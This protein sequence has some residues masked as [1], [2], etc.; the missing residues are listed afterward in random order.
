MVQPAGE[1]DGR[2]RRRNRAGQPSGQGSA[3]YSQTLRWDIPDPLLGAWNLILA[4]GS[5]DAPPSCKTRGTTHH[6]ETTSSL[7]C[8]SPEA[9][10]LQMFASIVCISGPREH[11]IYPSLLGHRLLGGSFGWG[12][13]LSRALGL[14]K[15][16]SHNGGTHSHGE[17]PGWGCGDPAFWFFKARHSW[18]LGFTGA[19]GMGFS[20]PLPQQQRE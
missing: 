8:L 20:G 12:W 16:R 13:V 18:S 19:F 15:S 4:T 5:L 14:R 9:L 6:P 10:V 17:D 1:S 11:F 2:S 3:Y 7:E